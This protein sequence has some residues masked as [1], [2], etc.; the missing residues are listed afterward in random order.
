[1]TLK[2]TLLQWALLWEQPEANRQKAQQLLT[3][4]EGEDLILLPE[5][6]STGFSMQPAPLAETWPGPSVQWMQS[7]ALERDALVLGSLI[8]EEKGSY[9]NRMMAAHPDGKLEF[10][11][12]RHL[13]RMAGE[14]EVYRG[15]EQKLIVEFRGWKICPLVCYDLRFPV[16]ARNRFDSEG[17]ADYDLLIYAANWPEKRS[18]HW[19]TL[20]KARAIENQAFVAGVNRVGEDGNGFSY[21]GD[22]AL[23]DYMGNALVENAREELALSI[24]IE[25]EGLEAWRQNFPIW[26]DADSFELPGA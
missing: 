25:K 18:A 24:E 9:F 15:G 14:H 17:K 2:I 6:F 20:L 7:L 1:M 26:K 10:A 3:S 19:R 13:F 12:K 8:I 11:D 4:V 5:M 23:I 21:R 16:W 22:S